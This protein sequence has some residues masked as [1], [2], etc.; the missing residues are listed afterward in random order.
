MSNR[1]TLRNFGSLAERVGERNSPPL[2]AAATL[3]V[4]GYVDEEE[5][6]GIASFIAALSP[7]IPYSLLAFHPAYSMRDLPTTSRAQAV[8]CFEAAKEAG[9]DRVKVGN[10]H[11]LI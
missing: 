3:L 1:Q 8:R 4:P 6:R 11:L 7:A 10:V 5:V 9:L 2:L